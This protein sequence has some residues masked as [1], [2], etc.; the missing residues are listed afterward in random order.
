MLSERLKDRIN[1][2]DVL[3]DFDE[4]I[5][6]EQSIYMQLHAYFSFLS[7]REKWSFSR[8]LIEAYQDYKRTEDVSFAYSLLAG[9]PVSI[10]DGIVPY[11]KQNQKW[12]DLI[13]RLNV[14]K[15]GIISRN[16]AGIISKYL[17]FARECFADVDLEIVAA[18]EP[19]IEE[20]IYTGRVELSVSNNN[21]EDF[22][23]D[24]GY[25]CG[26]DEK[27]ILEPQGFNFSCCGNGLFMV[28][29]V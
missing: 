5:I 3:T 7:L 22:V 6:K 25:I 18:N 8:K 29:N 28:G 15:V 19:E 23:Y 9:C 14:K 16:N 26:I 12:R 13:N 10:I 20:G 27:R 24:K 17:D 4:V 11:L 2:V 21:L 1:S